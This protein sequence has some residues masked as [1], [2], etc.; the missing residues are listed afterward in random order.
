VILLMT[1]N[2]GAREMARRPFGFGAG[3]ADADHGHGPGFAS[4]AG[5][6]SV[7]A[8]PPG[9]AGAGASPGGLGE[10]RRGRAAAPARGGRDAETERAYERLFSPEFR[11]RLDAKLQFQPLSRE[12]MEK[13][14]DKLIAELAVQLEPKAVRLELTPEARRLLAERGYDPAFGAR[15]L[16]RILDETVKQPLTQEL[17]FGALQAGGSAVVDIAAVDPAAPSG[18]PPEIVVSCRPKETRTGL[19]LG[20]PDDPD[21]V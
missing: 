10:G 9:D 6:A 12:V 8:E 18:E 4:A 14:V 19:D 13:I 21:E 11:N 3:E 15:P 17:L 7:V 16:A 5:G 1:S 2:L 20:G